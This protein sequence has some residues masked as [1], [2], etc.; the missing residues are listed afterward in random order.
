MPKGIYKRKPETYLKVS[1]SLMGHKVSDETRRKI[2]ISNL[3][4]K[5]TVTERQEMSIRMV[6]NKYALGM[7]HTDETKRKI[8]LSNKGKTTSEFNKQRVR[9]TWLGRKHTDEAIEKIRAS[10]IGRVH[11]PTSL[12]TRKKQSEAQR[13]AKGSNWKEGLTALHQTL[14]NTYEMRLARKS[15]CERDNLT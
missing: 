15:C 5:R 10:A 8:S 1:A 2:S 9:E 3:G 7:I 11:C 4:K 13:G 12:E 6:G 14:R